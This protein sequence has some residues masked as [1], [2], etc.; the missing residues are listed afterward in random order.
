MV[1]ISPR[2]CLA[3]FPGRGLRGPGGRMSHRDETGGLRRPA[4]DSTGRADAFEPN[5]DQVASH[6]R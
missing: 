5:V 2:L 1:L 6:R 4:L 3:I